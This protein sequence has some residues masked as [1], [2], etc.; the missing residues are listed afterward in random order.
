MRRLHFFAILLGALLAPTLTAQQQSPP[1]QRATGTVKSDATAILVD[2]VVR[3]KRGDP[4]T[5]LS[6]ADFE[7]EED[8]VAQQVGSVTLFSSPSRRRRPRPRKPAPT[9]APRRG[10]AADDAGA[11]AG[12]RAGVRPAVARSA[13][14]S[15][16]GPRLATSPRPRATRR[17][18][19]FG[20][21]LSLKIYQG[22]TGDA[23]LLKKAIEEVGARSSSQFESNSS[24]ANSRAIGATNAM[25]TVLAGV[26]AGGPGAAQAARRPAVPRLR[27]RWPRWQ[28]RT[29]ETFEVLE[30]DQQGYATSNSLLAL[31]NSMR[32]LP[33]PQVR[34]LLLRGAGH[35]AGRR[36]AVP[37]RHRHGQPRQRQH[38]RHG[39]GRLAHREHQQG[40]ARQHQRGRSAYP[41][42]ESHRRR[43]RHRR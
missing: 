25:N 7:V 2:V 36:R 40:D 28:R 35:P 26:A 20:I 23:A 34:H 9:A 4:I 42:Q 8:G 32:T 31:V 27:R 24:D 37:I 41:R 5:D 12:R 10:E 6:A 38:L 1:A 11:T 30:R 39:R 13:R 43:H 15:R 14:R 33:G 16:T 3:D 18:G 21:D 17:I 19:V 22:Y 29:M